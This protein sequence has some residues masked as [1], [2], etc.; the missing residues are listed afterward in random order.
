MSQL[1]VA[2]LTIGL[3]PSGAPVVDDAS[4]AVAAGRSLGIAGESG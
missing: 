1:S 4:I 3:Q 2:H